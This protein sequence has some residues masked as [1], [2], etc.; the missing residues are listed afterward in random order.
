MILPHPGD[1]FD[2]I[3]TPWGPAL[4]CRRLEPL[5]A[6]VFTSRSWSLGF[7][8]PSSGANGWSQVAEAVGVNPDR[9]LRVRQVHGASVV[10][11]R[12]GRPLAATA[13][14]DII[15]TDDATVAIAVQVADCVPVLLADERT[16]CAAAAHAGWRGL[17]LD[18]PA[19]AV[20]A[21]VDRF[22]TRPAD[23]LAVVGPS[24]GPCCYE[25]GDDVPARFRA[26][27]FAEQQLERWFS[28]HRT[29]SV[30]N[31]SMPARTGSSRPGRWF[32]DLWAAT[33]DGLAAAGVAPDRILVAELCTASHPEVFCSYR[34]DG[35]AAGRLAAVMKIRGSAS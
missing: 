21:M 14:A 5:A 7:T 11:H 16:G 13:E 20:G 9:L 18:V 19:R 25:V 30:R 10:E 24:I 22:G 6:S 8:G 3:A 2:W 1:G 31:P 15:V 29:A 26:A 33:R 17:A 4:V 12:A 32:L 34:R 27:P 23:V 28:T 35:S